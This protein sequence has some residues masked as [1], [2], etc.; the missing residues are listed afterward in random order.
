M[1][2][3][4]CGLDC[5]IRGVAGAKAQVTDKKSQSTGSGGGAL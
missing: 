5:I 1:N 4:G 3:S 2:Q